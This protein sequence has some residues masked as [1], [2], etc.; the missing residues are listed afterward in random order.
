MFSKEVIRF[1]NRCKDPQWHNLDRYFE[2]YSL[3]NALVFDKGDY[4]RVLTCVFVEFLGWRQKEE[5]PSIT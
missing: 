3:F 2:K 4:V 5:L 1:G